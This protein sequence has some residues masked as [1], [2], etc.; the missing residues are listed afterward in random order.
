MTRLMEPI[1]NRCIAN[2]E[3]GRLCGDISYAPD[4]EMG[5]AVCKD[6]YE[7][8]WWMAPHPGLLRITHRTDPP[9]DSN[10]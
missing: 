1:D 6:H 5:G 4:P 9:L 10:P 2:L 8:P 3:D 7:I